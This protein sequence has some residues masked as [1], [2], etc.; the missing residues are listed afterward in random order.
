MT[1]L[2]KKAFAEASS[3]PPAEQDAVANWLLAELAS[4]RRWDE[5]FA[6][7]R[8][9]LERLAEEALEDHRAGRTRKLDPDAL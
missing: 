6:S 1:K 3:L 9:A 8:S 5:A 7:S 2:L 4:E